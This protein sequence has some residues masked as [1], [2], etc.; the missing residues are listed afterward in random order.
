MERLMTSCSASRS[1][2]CPSLAMNHCSIA[3][4]ASSSLVYKI[5]SQ[6]SS[7]PAT[8]PG[9]MSISPLK[10]ACGGGWGMSANRVGLRM[11]AWV[12]PKLF[13]PRGCKL[14]VTYG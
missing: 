3:S 8:S 9:A 4:K 10:I 14:F 13:E 7:D 5:T 12:D 6:C 2:S 11:W 1:A